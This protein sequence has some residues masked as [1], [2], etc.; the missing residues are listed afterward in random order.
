MS[1]LIPG[2]T[3]RQVATARTLLR[4]PVTADPMWP[5]LLAATAL[6][7]TSVVFAG[8]AVLAPPHQDRAR[9]RSARRRRGRSQDRGERLP[10]GRRIVAGHR[11]NPR[12]S[13]RGE[14]CYG[15]AHE[16]GE[17]DLR[18]LLHVLQGHP[19]RR[20]GEARRRLVPTRAAS[21]RL[22]HLCGS[23]DALQ[24]FRCLWLDQPEMP[25]ALK[26]RAREGRAGL[27]RNQ[28]DC[29][30]RSGGTRRLAARADV[31]LPEAADVA[32]RQSA[33]AG[34]GGGGRRIWLITAGADH[35]LGEVDGTRPFRVEPGPDGK[36][37]LRLITHEAEARLR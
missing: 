24:V 11:R 22:Q 4:T 32:G 16:R 35:D 25:E 1:W 31:Q 36:P 13:Q 5:A 9:V 20:V 26:P 33:A 18:N 37:V 2:S 19:H 15:Q 21:R 12:P 17:S 10:S 28:A 34:H 8:V 6:A 30:L 3:R 7:V 14:R 23:A 29:P 27:Q